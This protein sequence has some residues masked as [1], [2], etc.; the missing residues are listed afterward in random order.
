M[1]FMSKYHQSQGSRDPEADPGPQFP[2]TESGTPCSS[3]PVPTLNYGDG[4]QSHPK[5]FS[6]PPSPKKWRPSTQ[7]KR[8]LSR[9]WH[10]THPRGESMVPSH[11]S[12]EVEI[13]DNNIFIG[14]LGLGIAKIP[15]VM[16]Y[17]KIFRKWGNKMVK[18]HYDPWVK[19]VFFYLFWRNEKNHP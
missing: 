12:P 17:E 14:N 2:Q 1:R 8:R 18:I 9:H 13:I 3:S 10:S 4:H 16:N 7:T 11:P 5:R 19:P 15:F 6:P